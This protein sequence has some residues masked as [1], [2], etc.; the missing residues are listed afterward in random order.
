MHRLKKLPNTSGSPPEKIEEIISII[1][2][3]DPIGVCAR[4]LSECLLI[5][6]KF[7]GSG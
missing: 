1:Q 3:F 2:T 6:A 4:D 7:L 5:Q